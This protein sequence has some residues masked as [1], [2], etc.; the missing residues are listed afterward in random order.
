MYAYT[1]AY[2]YTRTAARA[3]VPEE[4]PTS[5]LR[6]LVGSSLVT[7]ACLLCARARTKKQRRQPDIDT[8][9]SWEDDNGQ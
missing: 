4:V 6:L 2:T 7:L 9:N 1:Y 5:K 3:R 8:L